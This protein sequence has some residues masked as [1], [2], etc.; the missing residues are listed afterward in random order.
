MPLLK[1]LELLELARYEIKGG[2]KAEIFIRINDPSKLIF[3]SQ[4]KYT[5]NVLQN[6]RYSHKK[7]QDIINSF[8]LTNMT[9]EERWTLIE[10]Y[11]LGN[12]DYV[13]EEL[14]LQ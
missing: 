2:E 4:T 8:F 11:F 12:E 5:N 3:L 14:S 13:N 7:N 10:E 9:N 1:L 6:I